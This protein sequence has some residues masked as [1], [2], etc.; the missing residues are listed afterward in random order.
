LA[1]AKELVASGTF[2]MTSRITRFIR[3]HWDDRPRPAVAEIFA[4][5]T[6]DGFYKSMALEFEP[7]TVADVYHAE[8]GGERWYIKFYIRDGAPVVQMLSCNFDG[9]AH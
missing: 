9:F 3:E 6:A 5:L 7:E 4:S 1:Q 2:A 8:F